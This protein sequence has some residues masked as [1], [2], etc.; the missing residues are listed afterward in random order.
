MNGLVQNCLCTLEPSLT[1]RWNLG[2]PITNLESDKFLDGLAAKK[3]RPAHI[4]CNIKEMSRSQ[5]A[6][7]SKDSYV[8][9]WA[10]CSSVKYVLEPVRNCSTICPSNFFNQSF[11]AWIWAFDIAWVTS[12]C[13][14]LWN[15][16]RAW[17]SSASLVKQYRLYNMKL[18]YY[19]FN[20]M[21][22]E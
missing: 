6:Q 21:C 19:K 17:L 20:I 22:Q 13:A 9:T 10:Y 16:T 11:V 5:V 14:L 12:L 3:H 2:W 8:L 18:K 4:Y 7:T 15:T 1:W